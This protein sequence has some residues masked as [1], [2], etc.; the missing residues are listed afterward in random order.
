[1]QDVLVTVPAHNER[2]R[3]A[4]TIDSLYSDLRSDHL[5]Y[6]ISVAEDGSTD[7][8]SQ[9]AES[10]R[11]RHPELIVSSSIPRIGRGKAIRTLWSE[12]DFDFYCFVDSDLPAGVGAVRR[13]SEAVADGADIATGSRYCKGAIVNRPPAVKMASRAYNTTVRL[14]TRDG[15][16]DH[17]CGV[18]ALNRAAFG[19]LLPIALED[20]WFWDTELLVLGRWLGLNIA[21]IP[22]NWTETRYKKTSWRRLMREAPYFAARLIRVLDRLPSK[23]T[24][25]GVDDTARVNLILNR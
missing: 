8:T 12:H 11:E 5:S 19:E 4:A 22:L 14:L 1:M 18:K 15:I 25:V 21:E 16:S 3:I 24:N 17:Q 9:I 7:G 23:A 13:V 20:S 2:E 10:L 6:T